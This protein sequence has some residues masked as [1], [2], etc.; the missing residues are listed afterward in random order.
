MHI[1]KRQW[2]GEWRLEHRIQITNL[3]M[4]AL[5]ALATFGNSSLYAPQALAHYAERDAWFVVLIGGIIGLLNV[6]VFFFLNRLY[7]D[8]NLITI[9]THLFGKWIGWLIGLV[10]VLYLMDLASWSLREFTQFFIITLNPVIPQS[11][12]IVTG[13]IMAGFAVYHGL[14]T[15]ARVS[16]LFLPITIATFLTI[17]ILLFNQY[18][19]AYLLPVLENG[20]LQPLKGTMVIASWFGDLMFVSMMLQHVRKTK[21]TASFLM[22][23]VGITFFILIMSALTCTMVFGGKTTATFVYPNISLIQNVQLFRNIERFDAVL[24][25]I[26]VMGSFVKITVYL[27]SALHGLKELLHIQRLRMW[28]VPLA[29]ALT[30]VSKYKV[31]GLIEL[32]TF[33][34]KQ[35]WY[36]L[37]FQLG[38]PSAILLI[39]MIKENMKKGGG[40]NGAQ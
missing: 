3:Q 18:N 8:K 35:A 39:A 19:A 16:I 28:I 32:A 37:L 36:F 30:V 22:A 10:I 15:I 24:V 7:P 5:I 9:C 14:E 1:H 11:Y 13:A 25:V 33:Y 20:I 6:L 27:W 31:W 21:K 29:A 23:A 40:L 12:Y 4:M 34:E 26:W 17:Y 2:E 38:I